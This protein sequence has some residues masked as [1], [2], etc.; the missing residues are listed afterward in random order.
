M[1]NK[2]FFLV[3]LVVIFCLGS[4]LFG[5]DTLI[6]EPKDKENNNNSNNEN[7]S[8][9]INIY[10]DSLS[11]TAVSNNSFKQDAAMGGSS[12][13]SNIYDVA[14]GN[15]KFVAVGIAGQMGYSTDGIT[16]TSVENTGFNNRYRI[17]KIC[18][19]GGIF[20]ASGT[21]SNVIVDGKV[22]TIGRVMYSSNG[23]KWVVAD[24]GNFDNTKITDITYGNGKF[25]ILSTT[26]QIIYSLNG[27][28]WTPVTDSPFGGFPIS[29]IAYG[30]GR[31]IA[32]SSSANK[33]AYSSNG[34]TW[35]VLVSSSFNGIIYG[36]DEFLAWGNG[37]IATSNEGTTWLPISNGSYNGIT[38]DAKKYVSWRGN[39]ISYSLDGGVTWIQVENA[40]TESINNIVYGSDRFV[41]VG[42]NFG[43]IAFS[44]NQKL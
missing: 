2:H 3:L 13:Y 40:F 6:G 14:Y 32:V 33:I 10:T 22:T 9:K 24:T 37:V 18:Y 35:A 7:G 44:N 26:D 12:I 29:G 19:G 16:W 8:D 1:K 39:N 42:G 21:W 34:I 31:F 23:I 28:T 43:R 36:N 27:H 20:V 41:A 15:G 17:S 5:C 11:F 38:Y 25:F 4:L 30:A